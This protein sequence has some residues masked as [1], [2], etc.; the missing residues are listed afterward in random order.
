M[1]HV[2]QGG[3]QNHVSGFTITDVIVIGPLQNGFISVIIYNLVIE[4]YIFFCGE[5]FFKILFY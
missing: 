4:S 2:I 3:T 1:V 5:S